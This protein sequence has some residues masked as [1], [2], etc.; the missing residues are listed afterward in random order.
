MEKLLTAAVVSQITGRSTS[1][2]QKDR[3]TGR[4]IPY[5]KFGR[6]VRYRES[7]VEA[8][9]AARVRASIREPDQS[10]ELPTNSPQ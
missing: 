1:T 4:G 7:D 10:T 6:Q 9:Y 3:V 5:I 2:L 8:F